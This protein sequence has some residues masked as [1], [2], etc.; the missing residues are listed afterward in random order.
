VVGSAGRVRNSA[1]VNSRSRVVLV[2]TSKASSRVVN[3]RIDAVGSGGR[4]RNSAR[5][6]LIVTSKASSRV[7]DSRINA[8]GS[9]GRVHSSSIR[10]DVVSVHPSFL[11]HAGCGGSVA[12]RDVCGSG[13][14]V[15][16][17]TTAGGRSAV[18]V[19]A[20]AV[21]ASA[22]GGG[23]VG[24]IG[25]GDV[26]GSGGVVGSAVGGGGG[27]L[28]VVV[29]VVELVGDLVHE[30]HD[31]GLVVVVLVVLVWWVC[32]YC[33]G[34]VLSRR[35]LQCVDGEEVRKG[36]KGRRVPSNAIYYL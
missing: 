10:R 34:F 7:V 15:G 26:R 25:R 8:V 24:V 6:V 13:C 2:V 31:C 22:W 17:V 27:G 35:V 21:G 33:S 9:G 14:A 19:G 4:V 28:S 11:G 30:T 36:C 3:S 12:G 20:Q 18:V 1:G 5:V 23:L 32:L 29:L 16:S